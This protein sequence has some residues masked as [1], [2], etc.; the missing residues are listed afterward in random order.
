MEDPD[1]ADFQPIVSREKTLK[2]M[3][4]EG[5]N[6]S[7]VKRL[8]PTEFG[9]KIELHDRSGDDCDRISDRTDGRPTQRV[10][11]K[12]GRSAGP[13]CRDGHEGFRPSA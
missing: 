1:L 9:R 4:D 10:E 3:R 13:S 2:Q 11:V 12:D 6:T 7:V 5:V 8:K